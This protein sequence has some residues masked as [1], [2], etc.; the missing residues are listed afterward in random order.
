[1]LQTMLCLLDTSE[2]SK[3]LKQG[4]LNN[5]DETVNNVCKKKS[6]KKKWDIIIVKKTLMMVKESVRNGNS[7]MAMEMG[8]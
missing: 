8:M 1:M 6:C 2:L 4:F 3:L 5:N 7:Q